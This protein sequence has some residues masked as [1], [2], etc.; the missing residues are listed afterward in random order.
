MITYRQNQSELSKRIVAALMLGLTIGCTNAI[1]ENPYKYRSTK[2]LQEMA[3]SEAIGR[4]VMLAGSALSCGYTDIKNHY[5]EKVA[6]ELAVS[7]ADYEWGDDTIT[8]ALGGMAIGSK[9]Q[10][11]SD[12]LTIMLFS[13]GLMDKEVVCQNLI[14]QYTKAVN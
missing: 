11:T 9:V 12:N 14:K 3:E 4:D 7:L 10:S 13:Q 6:G 8:T 5:S 1:A 2:I